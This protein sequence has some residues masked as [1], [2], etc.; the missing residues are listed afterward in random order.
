MGDAPARLLGDT[1]QLVSNTNNLN[2]VYVF[3]DVTVQ[4]GQC[5]VVQYRASITVDS[6]YTL[7]ATAT[8]SP[9]ATANLGIIY[10]DGNGITDAVAVNSITTQTQ[11]TNLNVPST[12]SVK[13][14][15]PPVERTS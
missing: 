13:A 14:N 10:R 2:R 4:P 5:M 8:V 15:V 11:W 1:L 6:N 7:G 3:P 12:V 9:N